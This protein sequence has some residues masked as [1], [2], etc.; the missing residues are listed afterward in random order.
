M[1]R[2]SK[3]P[4][5]I[6]LAALVYARLNGGRV[7][8]HGAHRKGAFDAVRAGYAE[9]ITGY[10]ELNLRGQDIAD[11]AIELARRITHDR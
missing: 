6:V 7:K 9:A 3:K 4:T 1:G 5:L 11:E 10:A 8:L 2:A